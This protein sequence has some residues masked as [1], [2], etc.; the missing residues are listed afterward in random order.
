MLRILK[1]R[2]KLDKSTS[3]MDL[4]VYCRTKTEYRKD[5]PIKNRFGYIQGAGQ[6]CRQ[7]YMEIYSGEQS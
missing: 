5:T 6:L 1:R 3:D 4:C 7:C 2:M